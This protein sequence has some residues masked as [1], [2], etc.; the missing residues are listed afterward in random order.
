M[1]PLLWLI[2]LALIGGSIWWAVNWK[3]APPEAR[4]T[5]AKTAPIVD[6]LITN[7]KVEPV[8]YASVRA[9]RAGIVSRLLVEKG[10]FVEAGA[11]LAEL[12]N[13]DGKAAQEAA[14]AR[15]AQIRAEIDALAKGGRAGD[16]AELDGQIG[17]LQLDRKQAQTELAA[18]RRLIAKNAATPQSRRRRSCGR[19]S[20]VWSISSIHARAP[21]STPATCW[22]TLVESMN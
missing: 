18:V 5:V 21:F 15:V 6:T 16:L 22:P 3:N 7:G 14:N 4:F 13:A 17:R 1:K 12:E 20:R 8:E 19:R 9:E 10:Q 11:L 2:P